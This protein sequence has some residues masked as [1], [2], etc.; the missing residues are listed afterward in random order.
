MNGDMRFYCICNKLGIIILVANIMTTTQ[1][2]ERIRLAK[3]KFSQIDQIIDDITLRDWTKV[4]D[5]HSTPISYIESVK[6]NL[7][8]VL[9]ASDY[10][11]EFKTDFE[12]YKHAQRII[13]TLNFFLLDFPNLNHDS[14]FLSKIRNLDGFNFL[15]TMSELAVAHK[16]KTNGWDITFEEKYKKTT[17]SK[18]DIDIKVTNNIGQ[19]LYL[20]VY[21]PNEQA[22]INGFFNPLEYSERLMRKV[23]TKVMD[24]FTDINLGD[25]NGKRVLV[26]NTLYSDMFSMSRRTLNLDRFLYQLVNL[27]PEE[28]DAIL[29]FEDDFSSKDS[30]FEIKTMTRNYCG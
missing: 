1:L 3:T 17:G 11:D 24:K 23:E 21:A 6:Y 19:V 26:A 12:P 28:M 13:E 25:L 14:S 10:E 15:S 30:F 16:F 2:I 20:E 7:M 18:K 8:T 5:K 4:V 29:L 27:I 9:Y 22:E